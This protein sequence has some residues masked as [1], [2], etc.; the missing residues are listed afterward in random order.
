M[1]CEKRR[2]S[3]VSSLP[4]HSQTSSGKLLSC[5]TEPCLSIECE[6]PAFGLEPHESRLLTLDM[7]FRR[8]KIGQ[9]D[10]IPLDLYCSTLLAKKMW[11]KVA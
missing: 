9:N 10:I 1:K 6:L 11:S 8:E 2:I 5:R 3:A 7:N 4:E